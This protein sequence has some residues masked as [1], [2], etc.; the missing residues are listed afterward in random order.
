MTKK[1]D[2]STDYVLYTSASKKKPKIVCPTKVGKRP[3]YKF[4][5]EFEGTYFPLRCMLDLGSTS[6]VMSPEAAKAFRVPVVKR[7]LP[8]SASEVGGLQITTEGIFTIPLDSTFGNHRILDVE[9]YAFEV[10]KRTKDYNALIPAWYCNRH[11]AEGIMN[12][13]VHFPHCGVECFGYGHM[14]PDYTITY[15]KRIAL[16]PEAINIRAVVCN[17]PT[18]IEK[19]PK[20]YHKWL[21]LFDPGEAEK[22]PINRESDHRIELISSHDKLMMSPI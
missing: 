4:F 2:T 7:K 3:I 22:L 6:C 20:H 10:M 12:G 9:D 13:H 14:R 1:N 15:N 17:S 5:F 8:T 19:L 16:W 18:V 21:M 11:T